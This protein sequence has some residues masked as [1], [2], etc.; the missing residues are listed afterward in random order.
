[1]CICICKYTY[2]QPTAHTSTY[3]NPLSTHR[4]TPEHTHTR[5]MNRCALQQLPLPMRKARVQGVGKNSQ[6][7]ALQQI[8]ISKLVAN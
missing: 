8:C 4:Y 6:K 5:Q 7:S 3:Y 2:M 1:M